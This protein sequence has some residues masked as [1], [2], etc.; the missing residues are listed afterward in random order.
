MNTYSGFLVLSGIASI[1]CGGVVVLLYLFP[2]QPVYAVFGLALALF[3]QFVAG[4]MIFKQIDAE[5]QA[6]L[7][8]AQ[9][10]F[11]VGKPKASPKMPALS[12]SAVQVGGS[13]SNSTAGP[14]RREAMLPPVGSLVALMAE[15]EITFR[16]T[17]LREK[18][19]VE[20]AADVICIIDTNGTILSANPAARSVLGYDPAELVGKQIT[21]FL[22]GDGQQSLLEFLGAKESIN[23]IIVENRFRK[24]DGTIVDLL[25]SAH[26]S[27]SDE[28]LFCIAHDISQRK[29]AEAAKEQLLQMREESAAMRQRLMDIIVHDIRSPLASLLTTQALLLN[30][31]FGELNGPRMR[32]KIEVCEQEVQRIIGLINDLLTLSRYDA[33]KVNLQKASMSIT[34]L[35]SVVV[36]SFKEAALQKSV[37]ISTELVEAHAEIDKGM[38]EQVLETLISNAI[39]FSSPNQQITV[40]SSKDGSSLRVEVS[41]VGAGI[42]KDMETA[43]F[44]PYKKLDSSKA[45]ENAKIGIGLSICREIIESHGGTIGVNANPESGSCFYFTLPIAKDF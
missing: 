39:G 29:A 7:R 15:L 40:R 36:D 5:R 44:L 8:S 10:I 12:A 3:V 22:D 4:F 11:K 18:A 6:V 35:I 25:W 31:A 17:L 16:E 13:S 33:S 1:A 42:P 30:G 41:D 20:N 26:W 34:Q 14:M 38:I 21:Y 27:A 2:S 9:S 43:I 37:E 24:K 45:N 19:V 23:K 28:G 32:N